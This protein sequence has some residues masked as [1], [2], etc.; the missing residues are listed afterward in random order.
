MA[1]SRTGAL[2]AFE[3]LLVLLLVPIMM[4]LAYNASRSVIGQELF[5][6][7]KLKFAQDVLASWDRTGRLG[8]C[9]PERIPAC[10]KLRTELDQISDRAGYSATF[11][12]EGEKEEHGGSLRTVCAFRTTVWSGPKF[13][14]VFVCVD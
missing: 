5:D 4:L 14:R 7:Q 6:A 8:D 9:T 2:F 11:N 12:L 1:S 13:T 3:A 10:L